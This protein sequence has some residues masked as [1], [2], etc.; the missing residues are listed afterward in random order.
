M[1]KF[2]CSFVLAK[3]VPA[4]SVDISKATFI[5]PAIS[6]YATISSPFIPD[7]AKLPAISLISICD[8][9]P[10]LDNSAKSS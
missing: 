1:D 5:F 3:N 9:G 6:E 10:F 7:C 8:R 4:S 2:N